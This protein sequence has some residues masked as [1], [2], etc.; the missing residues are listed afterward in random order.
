MRSDTTSTEFRELLEQCRS[1]LWG[2]CLLHCHSNVDDAQD[3]Y[4]DIAY[5][6]W[7]NYP[8]FRNEC[9]PTT[10]AYRIALNT[11]GKHYRSLRRR[12]PVVPLD[13]KQ[14]N[15]IPDTDDQELIDTLYQLIE[16]LDSDDRTLI[17]LYLNDI[18]QKEIAEAL[19]TT[20]NAVNHRLR[21]LKEKLKKMN[22]HER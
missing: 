2:L 5:N 13:E 4:Q 6:L 14:H 21:R 19:D 11:L 22:D 8:D 9:K 15:N 12:V 7:K 20:K 3:L 1:S 18:P 10:W 17:D 16:N